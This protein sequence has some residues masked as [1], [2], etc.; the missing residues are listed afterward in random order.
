M[1]SKKLKKTKKKAPAKK[2]VV[3]KKSPA[4][5]KKK[6][7]AKKKTS[8]R[9]SSGPRTPPMH[10]EA[11]ELEVDAPPTERDETFE[12]F[13]SFDRDNSGSIDR[14]ELSRLLEA[15]GQL[16]NEDELNVALAVIDANNSG[17]IS[18]EE[19]KSWWQSR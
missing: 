8:S 12:I 1:A 3:A 5:T 17:R 2:K 14:A 7:P 13:K 19:F 10:A 9:K 4:K 15:L 16:P 18:W 6:A 11:P